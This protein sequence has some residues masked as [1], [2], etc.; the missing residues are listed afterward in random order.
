MEPGVH[1]AEWFETFANILVATPTIQL[2]S[3][4]ADNPAAAHAHP[5]GKSPKFNN[6]TGV[7]RFPR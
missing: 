5:I 7:V 1:A 4:T 6:S 3:G 2:T